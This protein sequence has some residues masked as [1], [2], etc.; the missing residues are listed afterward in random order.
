[1]NENKKATKIISDIREKLNKDLSFAINNK[2]YSYANEIDL[3]IKCL[4]DDEIEVIFPLKEEELHLIR[5][6]LGVNEE[7]KTKSIK[8]IATSTGISTS[9]VSSHINRAIRKLS[10]RCRYV[11]E[12]LSISDLG[13]SEE[14]QKLIFSSPMMQCFSDYLKIISSDEK[15]EYK[16][17]RTRIL[18]IIESGNFVIP[19]DVLNISPKAFNRLRFG[20]IDSVNKL[21][22]MKKSELAKIRDLDNRVLF[23]EIVEKTHSLGF[24]FNDELDDQKNTKTTVTTTYSLSVVTQRRNELLEK[25]KQLTSERDT[26]LQKESE[27]DNIIQNKLNA[28]N[29]VQNGPTKK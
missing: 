10:F 27:L 11:Q 8:D 23:D 25:E 5:E 19:L 29:G 13:M 12:Y 17:L 15:D 26:L 6:R 1:M 9:T 14:T 2:M 28:Q 16:E 3:A 22:E 18:P 4:L 20:G 7:N 21:I 24:K